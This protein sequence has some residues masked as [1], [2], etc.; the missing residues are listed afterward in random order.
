MR[1]KLTPA[2]QR[3]IKLRGQK[4]EDIR[5]EVLPRMPSM[6]DDCERVKFDGA[7]EIRVNVSKKFIQEDK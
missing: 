2:G 1:I 7:A 6:R 3:V 4:S 5:G